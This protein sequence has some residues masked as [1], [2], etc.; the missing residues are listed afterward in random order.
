MMTVRRVVDRHRRPGKS[1]FLS[2]GAVPNSHEFESMPG[3]AQIRVWFTPGPPATTPPAD[4][5]HG[6][7]RP[8]GARAR[9]GPAS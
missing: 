3:Q 5:A 1:V 8:G 6:Q 7:H 4:G 2:D 9:A